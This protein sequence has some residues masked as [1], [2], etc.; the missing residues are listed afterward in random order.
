MIPKAER[1][2]SD[3]DRLMTE[4]DLQAIVVTGDEH[5]SSARSYLANGARITHGEIIKKRGDAPILVVNPMEVEEAAK[6]GLKVYTTYEMGW[7]EALKANQGDPLKTKVAF[8]GSFLEKLAVPAG[9]IGIYG[10]GD[11]NVYIELIRLLEK[12]YPQYE[13]V[14]ER[15]T[16][17]FE[18]AVLTKDPDE[19][20]R[21]RSVADRTSSVLQ[22]TWDFIG[23]H[24]ANGQQVVKADGTPLTIGDVKRFVRRALLDVELE[25]TDMI[26]AQ[27]R[28]GGFPHSRGEEAMPLQ[29][30]EAIV[31]DLFPREFGGGYFHDTTRTWCIGYAPAAV[32]EIYDTVMEAFDVA[33]EAYGLGKPTHTMQEAVLK[34]FEDKGHPTPRSQPGTTVGYVHSLGHGLGLEIHERPSITHVRQEDIFQVGNVVTIEPGLYYPDRGF[35]VRVEDTF[36]VTQDGQLES[37]TRFHKD[38]VLPLQGEV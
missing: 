38:L 21:I 9:K 5:P 18:A 13:F 28:D 37:L 36:T 6:S 23:A 34:H 27:G 7:I 12:T 30:G 33:V 29:L 8:W 11:L 31:F 35:G 19:L 32:Q 1:M 20:N 14:G 26:F 10:V 3:L 4:R 15:G 2:K 24:K 25:D 22:A 17:L 16:T